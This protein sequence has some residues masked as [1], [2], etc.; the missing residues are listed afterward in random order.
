M[1]KAA[2]GP[3]GRRRSPTTGRVA[4]PSAAG[5]SAAGRAGGRERA[6]GASERTPRPPVPD[7]GAG[8]SIIVASWIGTALFTVTA[9]LAAVWPKQLDV[10]AFVVSLALFGV[11]LVVFVWAYGLAVARSRSDEIAVTSLFLLATSA[12]RRVQKQLL[13][14]L[15]AQVVVALAT[16]G[17]RVHTTLAFGALVPLFGLALAG[18][19]SA[20][21]GVF[22]PRIAVSRR[23][24]KA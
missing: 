6:K 13:G 5:A 18:L 24:R 16:A 2:G 20:R 19:W 9:A 22:P 11:G 4:K 21:H 3:K 15:A 23:S 7:T 12:P 17:A 8:G 1:N 10:P 14:S